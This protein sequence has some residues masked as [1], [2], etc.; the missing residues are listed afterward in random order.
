[1]E[2]EVGVCAGNELEKGQLSAAAAVFE[3]CSREDF[4][5]FIL[6]LFEVLGMVNVGNLDKD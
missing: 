5:N 4:V 3:E 6:D 1:M 2:Q